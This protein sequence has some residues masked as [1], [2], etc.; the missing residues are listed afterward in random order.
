MAG[1]GGGGGKGTWG[2]AVKGPVGSH[3]PAL[4]LTKQ[5]LCARR[6]WKLC[7]VPW[8]LAQTHLPLC[9]HAAP[10]PQ[11]WLSWAAVSVCQ[12]LCPPSQGGSW[13]HESQPG[14]AREMCQVSQ[15]A[16]RGGAPAMPQPLSISSF[17]QHQALGLCVCL[18]PLEPEQLLW[19]DNNSNHNPS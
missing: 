8:A 14:G 5:L 7:Q 6:P 4:W 1:E 13:S 10:L 16:H 15:H 3:T 19:V 2:Q 18:L 12:H 17:Y 11:A 9:S